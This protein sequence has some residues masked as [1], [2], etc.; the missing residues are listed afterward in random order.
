MSDAGYAPLVSSLRRLLHAPAVSRP[1]EACELCGVALTEPHPH[2]VD[3]RTRRLLC[4]CGLCAGSGRF[5]AVP[6]RYLHLP[7][8][9]LSSA[10]WDIL[11]IPVDLAFFFFNS[12]LGRMV[13]FYPGPAGVAES[14]LPLDAL[15]AL[16]PARDWIAAL[17]PDV[18]ALLVR[19]T[20]DQFECFI[21]PID[22]CY[23][24]AGRIRACWTGLGGGDAV[25]R[26][27]D[28]FF[29]AV[30]TKGQR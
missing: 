3:V 9:R 19:K 28:G 30:R 17:E 21:V 15:P 13:A 2:V 16:A 8:M 20:G 12:G 18:E 6:S 10:Q 5:R 1:G 26:E 14:L 25:R 7:G 27:I 4:T 11:A 24:L 23:E 29:D 22:A